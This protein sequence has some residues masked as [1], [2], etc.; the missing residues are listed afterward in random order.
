M[1]VNVCSALRHIQ[2]SKSAIMVTRYNRVIIGKEV[3]GLATDGARKPLAL[4]GHDSRKECGGHDWV[5][6]CAA[7]VGEGCVECAGSHV[8]I[9]AKSFGKGPN[10]LLNP[11]S[12][13]PSPELGDESRPVV[14]FYAF[15]SFHGMEM[16]LM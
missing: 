14:F 3:A 8:S 12:P 13:P 2:I 9:P 16:S 7:T 15:V 5:L 10:G 4:L 1:T 11:P 6:P